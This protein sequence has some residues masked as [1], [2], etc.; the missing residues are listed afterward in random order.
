ME[1]THGDLRVSLREKEISATNQ[2]KAKIERLDWFILMA[3]Q[4][5]RDYLF[6]LSLDGLTLLEESSWPA[7]DE[8]VRLCQDKGQS[9]EDC[10]NY[11]RVLHIQGI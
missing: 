4:R 10:H 2:I 7:A 3:S 8:L 9:E 6:R 11:I 1:A 5:N